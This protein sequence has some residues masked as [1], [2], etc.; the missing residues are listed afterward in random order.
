MGVP[1]VPPQG[2]PDTP[3][4]FP[5]TTL[6]AS[7]A[8]L[9]AHGTAFLQPRLRT[10]LDP[11]SLLL[12]CNAA[13]PWPGCRGPTGGPRRGRAPGRL[14]GTGL[15]DR[16]NADMG[17]P[18]WAAA[19]LAAVMISTAIYCAGRLAAPRLRR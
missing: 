14:A 10:W 1:K 9:P 2:F 7:Q 13:K 11:I 19:A 12:L 6:L 18:S 5:G 4:R 3:I 15:R 8:G 17:G 16:E